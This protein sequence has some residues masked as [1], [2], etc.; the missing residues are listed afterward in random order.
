MPFDEGGRCKEGERGK[1]GEK[2]GPAGTVRPPRPYA[3]G[4]TAVGD[5]PAAT[6]SA[7]ALCPAAASSLDAS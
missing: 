2:D 5:V 1:K 3:R 6:A 4:R 7:S